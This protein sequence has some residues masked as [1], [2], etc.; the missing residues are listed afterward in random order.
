MGPG[1]ANAQSR[2]LSKKSSRS[3][4]LE[5]NNHSLKPP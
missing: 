2:L 3:T 1:V 4:L 5:L